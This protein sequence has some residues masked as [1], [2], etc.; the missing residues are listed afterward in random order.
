MASTKEIFA[1]GLCYMLREEQDLLQEYTSGIK[2]YKV[3]A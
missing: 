2:Y 3:I 1:K